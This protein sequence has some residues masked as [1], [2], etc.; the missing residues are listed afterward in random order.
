[1]PLL[2]SPPPF[3]NRWVHITKRRI[4]HGTKSKQGESTVYLRALPV[5]KDL[6]YNRK[7]RLLIS[8]Q[9]VSITLRDWTVC[10]TEHSNNSLIHVKHMLGEQVG[11]ESSKCYNARWKLFTKLLN[12]NRFVILDVCWGFQKVI[13]SRCMSPILRTVIVWTP[14]LPF[15]MRGA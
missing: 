8:E 6:P 3:P 1:M 13:H 12:G 9:Q 14:P 10:Q 15:K 5:W 4:S 7:T 2:R 11:F